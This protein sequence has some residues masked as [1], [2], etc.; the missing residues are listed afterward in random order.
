MSTSTLAAIDPLLAPVDGRHA[1]QLVVV[2]R[3]GVKPSALH[4]S[5]MPDGRVLIRHR[6]RAVELSDDLAE[7]LA[8]ELAPVTDE[9]DVFARAFTGIVLTSGTD[10]LESWERFYRASLAR[11][12]DLGCTGYIEIYRHALDLLPDAE[13]LDLGCGFGFLALHLAGRGATVTGC[14]VD[15]GALGLL[16]HMS[17]RLDRP[18]SVCDSVDGY[19][20]KP[21][22]S[23]D[24]VVMLHVLEHVEPE[25][26]AVLISEATRVARDRVVIAVPYE[27]N[28][29][30]MYGHVRALGADNLGELG[31]GS[32]WSYDVHDHHGGWLV[33]DRPTLGGTTS[34]VR[35]IG[36]TLL[37]GE[38]QCPQ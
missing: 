25:L 6:L 16:R 36:T 24:A 19:I 34:P 29:T 17:E 14:D 18:V 22:G 8:A 38:L 9:W 1:D 27:D 31:A 7:R 12:D 5:L 11:L 30:R 3:E 37:N 28:P 2:E 32:G 33:L 23:V 15:L 4:A 10:P 21:S 35:V 13:V 26:G 20:P